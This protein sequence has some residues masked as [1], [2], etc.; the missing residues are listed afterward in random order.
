MVVQGYM[1][2]A[3]P[4]LPVTVAVVSA[5]QYALAG[6]AVTVAVPLVAGYYLF[7]RAEVKG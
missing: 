2:G 3:G 4:T 7:R 1:L 6:L 5:L